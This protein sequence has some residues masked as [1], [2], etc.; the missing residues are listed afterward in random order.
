MTRPFATEDV[1]AA[2]LLHD[3]GKLLLGRA[4]PG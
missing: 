1:V 2:A 3:I 4:R